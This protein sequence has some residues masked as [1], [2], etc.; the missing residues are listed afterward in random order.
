MSLGGDHQKWRY[1]RANS[2]AQIEQFSAVN[3]EEQVEAILNEVEGFLL[4]SKEQ[5]DEKQLKKMLENGLLQKLLVATHESTAEISRMAASPRSSYKHDNGFAKLVV[6]EVAGFKIRIHDFFAG[7]GDGNIHNHRWDL[8]SLVLSGR[9]DTQYF[10]DNTEGEKYVEHRYVRENKAVYSIKATGH[11]RLKTMLAA[12]MNPGSVYRFNREQLH[13]INPAE[14]DTMTLVLTHPA[15][16]QNCRLINK[17]T[18][19]DAGAGN[20][21]KMSL[22]ET[23]ITDILN[24]AIQSIDDLSVEELV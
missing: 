19:D 14:V 24:R 12:E 3:K 15:K 7:V 11:T 2:L 9:L 5:D 23:E 20:V 4:G 8:E 10:I 1:R 18:V 16:S 22:S 6:A 21:C 13:R 17:N